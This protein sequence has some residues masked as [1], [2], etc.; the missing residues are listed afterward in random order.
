M[1]F[2]AASLAGSVVTALI[3]GGCAWV[4]VR[5]EVATIKQ[6]L[7][8]V[9]AENERRFGRLEKAVGIAEG[10]GATFVRRGECSL[11]HAQ[12]NDQFD[13]IETHIERID[14]HLERLEGKS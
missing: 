13:R 9:V 3:V 8:D 14:A 10:N 11:L 4:G 2:D 5:V 12:M 7:T 1:T 6:Q